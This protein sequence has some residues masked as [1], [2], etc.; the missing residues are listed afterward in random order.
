MPVRSGLD[1]HKRVRETVVDGPGI[2]LAVVDSLRLTP[3]PWCP[4]MDATAK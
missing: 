1:L 4:L 3:D 2:R